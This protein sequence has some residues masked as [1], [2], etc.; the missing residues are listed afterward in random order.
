MNAEREKI[1]PI[2]DQT[3]RHIA[4]SRHIRGLNYED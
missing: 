3:W 1:G 2:L 4:A